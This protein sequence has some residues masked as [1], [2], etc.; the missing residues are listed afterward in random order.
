MLLKDCPVSV[1]L[2]VIGGKWKPLLLRELKS[3]TLR[4]GELRRRV[5]EAAPKVLTAQLRQLE[6]SG[7][8]Q[9]TSFGGLTP[10]TEYRL[11]AYGRTL[12]PILTRLS[13]W[14]TLHLQH[15]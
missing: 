3:G 9:R 15:K 13:E 14:G 4:Y 12:R 10:R 7:I 6:A 5:P 1:A 11:T 2:R 8:V